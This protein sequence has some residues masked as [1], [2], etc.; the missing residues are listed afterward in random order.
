MITAQNKNFFYSIAKLLIITGVIYYL[1]T[2][3]DFSSVCI[4]M[5]NANLFY[6]FPALLLLPINILLQF[7]KWKM[8]CNYYLSDNNNS[9]VWR[10]L[11]AGFSAALF[12]P[13]RAGE[14][15]GRGLIFKDKKIINIASAVFFDKLFT[16]IFILFFGTVSLL[17]F[18]NLYNSLSYILLFLTVV[19]VLTLVI[20]YLIKSIQGKAPGNGE[21]LFS[22]V[23]NRIYKKIASVRLPDRDFTYKMLLLS[24]IFYCCY[25]L[26]FALLISA[27]TSNNHIVL[28][29]TLAGIILAVKTLIPNFISGELG[30]RESAT[31]FFLSAAGEN[32]AAGFNASIFLF[33]INIAIPAAVGLFF[34][35]RS[36]SKV[37]VRSR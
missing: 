17:L 29:L 23:L 3:V 13:A 6:F 30:I 10:S 22:R 18:F 31:V 35:V 28:H 9:K 37:D 15:I 11:F 26:Q 7:Y 12:T 32:S 21:N 33:V 14:Y 34:L 2:R 5:I 8:S 27:F 25:L 24:F 1:A 36:S 4:G 19:I 20:T 16:L